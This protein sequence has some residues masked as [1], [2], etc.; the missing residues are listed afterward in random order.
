MVQEAVVCG[1][2]RLLPGNIRGKCMRAA[3]GGKNREKPCGRLQKPQTDMWNAHVCVLRRKT[4]PAFVQ[5]A[6]S[7]RGGENFLALAERLPYTDAYRGVSH[8]QDVARLRRQV[9]A[10]TADLAHGNQQK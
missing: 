5:K 6:E 4:A 7:G 8:P 3:P 2:L 10:A 9:S 1:L